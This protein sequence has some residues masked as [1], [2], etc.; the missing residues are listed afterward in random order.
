M[1]VASSV[2]LADAFTRAGRR[3]DLGDLSEYG[4]PVPDE[5]VFARLRRTGAV[6]AIVDREVIDAIKDGRIEVVRGVEALDRMA[7]RLA[8]GRSLEP[9]ALVAATGYRRGLEPLVG[10]LGVLKKIGRAHV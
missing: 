6:P 10:H 9:D 2:R 8:D 3:M 1:S 5:G 7:V 4:L